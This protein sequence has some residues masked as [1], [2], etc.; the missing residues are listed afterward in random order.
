MTYSFEDVAPVNWENQGQRPAPSSYYGTWV[1]SPQT[2]PLNSPLKS[3]HFFLRSG[4]TEL[5]I[6][7][8][9]CSPPHL[10]NNKPYFLFFKTLLLLFVNCIEAR[11]PTFQ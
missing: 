10:M 3:G 4:M 8:S 5:W 6:V 2:E 1:M 7:N 11:S 9:P